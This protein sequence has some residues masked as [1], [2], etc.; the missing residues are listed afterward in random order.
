M[1]RALYV[2]WT[3]ENPISEAR[4]RSLDSMKNTGLEVLFITPKNL[5][6]YLPAES[7]HPA[8]AF[9]NLAHKADYLRCYFMK[10]HG[11]GYSDLKFN[12]A[13]W[14]DVFDAL[15]RHP[16][17]WA[18]GYREVAPH[19]V[20]DLYI[21]SR[22]LRESFA[23]SFRAQ[24]RWRFLQ[25]NYQKLIG[26]CA[27]IFKKDTPLVDE[28]WQALNQRLDSLYPALEK[29]PSRHPKEVPG[30]RIDGEK[31]R[32]PVPWTHLL[33]DI[34]HPLAYKYHD[35]LIYDLPSPGFSNYV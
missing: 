23:E 9:L 8:Y 20:A 6:E 5:H 4:L 19:G 22:Q 31:S 7:L 1:N 25:M 34:L 29:N 17:A 18:A 15:D 30:M 28:W 33:G 10:H 11:G 16:D 32:Y 13:S 21:S 3:G 35:R 2:F 27:F 14:L 12:E 24:L 26:T